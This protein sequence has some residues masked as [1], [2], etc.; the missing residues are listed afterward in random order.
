MFSALG[1]GD[2]SLALY[3]LASGTLFALAIVAWQA[4]SA[5]SGWRVHAWA[6]IPPTVFGFLLMLTMPLTS[7][8]LFYR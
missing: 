4:A 2:Q 5:G 3:I 1:R 8:D 6:L 7:R